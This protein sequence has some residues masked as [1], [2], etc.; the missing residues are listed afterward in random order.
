MNIATN[1]LYKLFKKSATKHFT[2]VALFSKNEKIRYDDI[3][4]FSNR[5]A[6]FLQL[7]GVKKGDRVGIFMENCWEYI[8]AVFS[9]LATGATVVPIN[10]KIKSKEL[11]F[12]LNDA[13]I[14]Y[15]F[16]CDKLSDILYKSIAI[17]KCKHIIWVGDGTTGTRFKNI[18]NQDLVHEDIK[19]N[20]E[21]EAFIFFTSATEGKAKGAILTNR[22]ILTAINSVKEHIKLTAKDRTIIFLPFNHSFILLLFVLT[23]LCFGAS[24]VLT[25]YSGA[26]ELLKEIALKRVTILFAVPF[27]H[28]E[29]AN[30]ELTWLFTTFNKLRLIISGGS[31]ISKYIVKMLIK[32]FSRANFI[33][34]Y[35]LSES[36]AIIAANPIGKY[37]LASVG[38]PINGCRVKIVD[39]Y[40]VELPSNTIGEIAVSGD[41]IMKGYINT[42]TPNLC[43]IKNEWLYTGDMGYLDND[44]YLYIVSRKKDLIISKIEHIY[45]QEIEELINSYEGIKESAVVGKQNK[46]GYE[47]PIAFIV[48]ESKE[49]INTQNLQEY[50]KGFLAQYKIPKEYIFIEKLP[51]NSSQ[52]VLKQELKNM[53]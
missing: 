41:N 52:K 43:P 15:L 24:A 19:S 7:I 29:I 17:H 2:K 37:K 39:S 12:V 53:L 47:E 13:N 34:G 8:V 42:N 11:S 28:N 10:H 1:S 14:N 5:V 25:T 51:R 20:L 4:F 30:A 27:I 31:P 33:E 9:I 40:N 18:I 46:D 26:N 38:L 21:D 16:S 3:L 49:H 45:P 48:T 35:G 32:K 23:P 22:N 6:A 44:G 50:L 36:S